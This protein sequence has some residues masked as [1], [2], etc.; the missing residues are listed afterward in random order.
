MA[1]KTYR[2]QWDRTD[3]A[4]PNLAIYYPVETAPCECGQVDNT[5][6][7][8]VDLTNQTPGGATA[9]AT[10]PF[11]PGA[12][13]ILKI[14][15]A[16]DRSWSYFPAEVKW[17]APSPNAPRFHRSGFAFSSE[18]PIDW[19]PR[20]KTDSKKRPSSEDYTFF[21][22]INILKRLHRDAVCPLLNAL[23]FRRVE[24]GE[25]FVTQGEAGDTIFIIQKG[26]CAIIIEKDGESHSIAM[27]R[28]GDII[29]EMS[30]LTGEPRSAH[31][32]AG[33]DMDLWVL[34]KED[35]EAITRD[36]PELR[37]FLTEIVAERFATSRMT[38]DREIG[39]YLI[40]DIIGRGGFSI[41][42]KGVHTR[43]NMPV[44][45]K[46]LYH[47]M[48]MEDDFVNN[49]QK[50]AVTIA[51]FN[52]ENI[53][54]VYDVE[55]CYQTMFIVMEHVRGRSL[56][57]IMRDRGS[58]PPV[59]VVPYLL[60]V[61]AGLHYAHQRGIIHQDIKPGNL[62]ILPDG[63]LKILDFGLACPCG[64]ENMMTGTPFYMAPEQVECLPVDE[65]TDIYA[66]GLT[67][68]EMLAGRKA[69]LEDDPHQA[70]E[71]HVEEDIPDPAEHIPDCPEGLRQIILKACARDVADRYP[72]I[73]DLL[74]DLKPL[75]D[76]LGV[77]EHTL[78]S[79]KKRMTTLFLIYED[80][81]QL[82]L[83]RLLE[84]FSSRVED[85]GIT[86]KAADFN[87]I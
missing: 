10:Q 23:V 29:G 53:I 27:R 12:Q 49:F 6:Q 26:T 52:H 82:E 11:E 3:L 33:T 30:L 77:S 64:E 50:E 81:H 14:H 84:A 56:R 36:Y 17:S 87:D 43:L 74:H 18:V 78:V 66:L 80:H 40:T 85:M 75:A 24:A 71:L 15:N 7:R 60:Q 65:R 59:E 63:R 19:P 48:A 54:K 61:C 41:V 38:A 39:R 62:F 28:T 46:M 51:R 1:A 31:V 72:T 58:L 68:F 37:N 79:P 21:R 45:I 16:D 9:L 25:R 20:E 69:F 35:F 2:R 22:T 57:Q 4:T 13:C 70:M 42:Y 86:L 55:S 73:A 67:A 83:N 76:A 8:F 44:A 32:E 5:C 47:D 34:K